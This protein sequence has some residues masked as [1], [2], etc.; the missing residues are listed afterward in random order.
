MGSGC[1]R[2]ALRIFR[3]G[4][5][6]PNPQAPPAYPKAYRFTVQTR[7]MVYYLLGLGEAGTP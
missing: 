6:E 1:F 4:D 2:T 7:G 3:H 5:L